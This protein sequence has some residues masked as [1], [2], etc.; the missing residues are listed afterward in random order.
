MILPNKITPYKKSILSKI[1]C[2]LTV[3]RQGNKSPVQLWKEIR[4]EFEDINEYILTMDVAFV[5]G[6]LEY[7]KDEQ[8]IRYVKADNMW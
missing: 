5:L 7:L 6:A 2:V 3:L 8:V 4:G 1:P